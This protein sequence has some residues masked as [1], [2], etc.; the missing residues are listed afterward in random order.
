MDNIV[1]TLISLFITS[2]S[3]DFFR[4]L[5]NGLSVCPS[6]W[7]FFNFYTIDIISLSL[8]AKT[9]S[10]YH[11]LAFKQSKENLIEKKLKTQ[12]IK[13]CKKYKNTWAETKLNKKEM[14]YFP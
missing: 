2:N 4:Y 1:T 7:F 10:F 9:K 14:T 13:L 5:L 8:V 11:L 12:L 3:N 6:L